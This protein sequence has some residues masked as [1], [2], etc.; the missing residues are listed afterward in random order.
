[1]Q[2]LTGIRE[3]CLEWPNSFAKH[4]QRK[5]SY[6]S[7]GC[8]LL[9]KWSSES[10]A[11]SFICHCATRKIVEKKFCLQCSLRYNCYGELGI[12]EKYTD[13]KRWKYFG[14][15][16]VGFWRGK[17]FGFVKENKECCSTQAV[18]CVQGRQD[19]LWIKRDFSN[20][21]IQDK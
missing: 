5:R 13:L 14:N 8:V 9:R 1:M 11:K 12:K 17:W 21:L 6:E 18:F 16:L 3:G 20:L 19:L 15:R 4:Q 7:N 2:C 10:S